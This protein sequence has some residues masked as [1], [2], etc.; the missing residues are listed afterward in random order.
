MYKTITIRSRSSYW[1]NRELHEELEVDTIDLAF[2]I[3]RKCNELEEDG[4][5]ILSVVP[6]TSGNISNGNGYFYTESVIVTAH[7]A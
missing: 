6:V 2:E 1:T 7:K 3:E 5:S 4:W